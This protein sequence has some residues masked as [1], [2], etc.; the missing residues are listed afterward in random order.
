MHPNKEREREVR[1]T[2]ET[3]A[4][5][6][7]LSALQF[8]NGIS[9]ASTMIK[10]I[11]EGINPILNQYDYPELKVRVGIDYGDVA[12]VQYGIDIYEFNNVTL[13]TPH[14]DLIGY[15]ISVAV[16][17]TSLAEP[18]RLVIGQKLYDCLNE[19]LKGSFKKLEPSTE[20]WSYSNDTNDGL[21]TIFTNK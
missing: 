18:D 8:S 19:D 1:E 5:S 16:K 2:S 10:V 11:K 17:M 12:V 4:N 7:D 3:N 14:L 13:K 21:Y 15:T 9:C 20:I 6:N